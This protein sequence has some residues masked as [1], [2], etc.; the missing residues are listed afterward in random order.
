MSTDLPPVAVCTRC[1]KYSYNGGVI[2]ERCGQRISGKRCKGMY[3]S[4]IGR[5]DWARCAVCGG[6]RPPLRNLPRH[7]LEFRQTTL[8]AG[9]LSFRF[10]LRLRRH[11]L[12]RDTL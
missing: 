12:W 3:Q 6:R 4:A 1:G 8:I 9:S 7:R 11:A 2:N 10:F 5:D